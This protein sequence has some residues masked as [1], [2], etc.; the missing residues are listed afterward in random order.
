MKAVYSDRCPTCKEC[1][2]TVEHFILLCPSSCLCKKVLSVC[3]QKNVLPE[4]GKVL[5]NNRI[6]DVIF[7]NLICKI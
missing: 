2:E 1:R 7:E 6:L 3:R 5:S 4:I